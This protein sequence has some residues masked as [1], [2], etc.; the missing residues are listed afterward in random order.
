MLV[1]GP[2][3]RYQPLVSGKQD[4]SERSAPRGPQPEDRP[5][6]VRPRII[7]APKVRQ[8]YWCDFWR[9]AQLPEMWKTRPVV[10]VSYKNTLH[11]PCLVVPTTTEPQ[12]GNP[13]ACKLTTSIDGREAW[14]IC[15]QPSTVAPSRLSPAK[16]KILRISEAEFNEVL[17][18]LLR[19]LP[20]PFPLEGAPGNA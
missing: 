10:V 6:R 2:R 11:G 16:G 15:N 5:P 20:R 14:A 19:W 12:P 4:E 1:A 3:A 8:L 9:D 17:A 7:A 18:Q 13:W